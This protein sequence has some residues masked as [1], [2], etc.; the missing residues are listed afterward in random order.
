MNV[1]KRNL[2]EVYKAVQDDV[3]ACLVEEGVSAGAGYPGW[4]DRAGSR[5]FSRDYPPI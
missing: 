3:S 1:K 5:H 4:K 2:N